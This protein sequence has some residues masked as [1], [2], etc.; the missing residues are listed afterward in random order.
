MNPYDNYLEGNV[1]TA[2]P[3]ELVRMLY[4]F[5]IERMGDA[6]HC[7]NAG[8]I[9]GRGL[10][11]SR[12]TDGLTE[13]LCSLDHAHGGNVSRQLAE[14]YG[15]CVSRVLQGHMEQDKTPFEEV[16]RLMS[17]LLQGWEQVGGAE[18]P[19]RNAYAATG[20]YAPVSASY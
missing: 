9:V 3:I 8:D 13:L 1:L 16:D 17:T 18:I 7:S 6:I 14:L 15:Y 12:A 4:R 5:V 20:S 19:A 11:V 10:A 2:S